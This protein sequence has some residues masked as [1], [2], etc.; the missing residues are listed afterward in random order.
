MLAAGAETYVVRIYRR[1][2]KDSE[3]LVGHSGHWTGANANQLA[4]TASG[5]TEA[6]LPTRSRQSRFSGAATRFSGKRPFNV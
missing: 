1:A 4:M 6:S 5:K 3:Q 2:A